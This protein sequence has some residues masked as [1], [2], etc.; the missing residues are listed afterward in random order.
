MKG[1]R[2][3]VCDG[4]MQEVHDVVADAV[5]EAMNQSCR[6]EMCADNAD[7]DVLGRIGALLRY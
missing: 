2:C 1:R 7:L 6:V 4:Q 5:D 3:K